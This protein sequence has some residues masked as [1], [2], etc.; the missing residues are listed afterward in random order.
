MDNLRKKS[1]AGV[2]A[3]SSFKR[4][5]S[6]R[7]RLGTVLA[8]VMATIY[9]AFI[10]TVAF[11]PGALAQPIFEGSSISIGIAVGVGIMVT[12]FILTAIY[13]IYA[14]RRLDPMVEALRR[15]L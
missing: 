14:T 5:C 4:L 8:I 11:K 1:L 7:N 6:E 9:F 3:R 10:S 13:V 12:G 15:E 2:A